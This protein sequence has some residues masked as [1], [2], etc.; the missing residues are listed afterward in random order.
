[1]KRKRSEP[2]ESNGT[3]ILFGTRQI[4]SYFSFAKLET[5]CTSATLRYKSNECDTKKISIYT[6]TVN[7]RKS[8]EFNWMKFYLKYITLIL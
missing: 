4:V 2:A 3:Q 5:H 7:L 6:Q 1:M 8:R